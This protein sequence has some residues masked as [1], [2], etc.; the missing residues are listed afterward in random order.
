M[1]ENTVTAQPADHSI[2]QRK[3]DGLAPE[4][5]NYR[6]ARRAFIAMVLAPVWWVVSLIF[7]NL[8]AEIFPSTTSE[9]TFVFVTWSVF[10]LLFTVTIVFTGRS[11][12]RQIKKYEAQRGLWLARGAAI[13]GIVFTVAT[14]AIVVAIFTS[15]DAATRPLL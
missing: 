6:Q 8:L 14:L 2:E 9:S 1:E 15:G 3:I 11:H 5:W 13:G 4:D 10:S 12:A 7:I